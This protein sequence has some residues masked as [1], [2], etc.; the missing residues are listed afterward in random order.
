[1]ASHRHKSPT[2]VTVFFDGLINDTSAWQDRLAALPTESRGPEFEFDG[3]HMRIC[4]QFEKF[5]N[6]AGNELRKIQKKDQQALLR[7]PTLNAPSRHKELQ[8][9]LEP[10]MKHSEDTAKD[11]LRH[12][13]SGHVTELQGALRAVQ[14]AAKRSKTLLE[15]ETEEM[16]K[17]VQSQNEGP[18][19]VHE[20]VALEAAEASQQAG[21]PETEMI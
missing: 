20:L 2:D 12:G 9:T 6:E 16:A 11:L 1:M 8:M 14:G 10:L 17:S 4:E 18:V 13:G 3:E 5:I 15:E 21:I 19:E 7:E